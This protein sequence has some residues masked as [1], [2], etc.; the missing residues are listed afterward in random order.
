LF[1][2][3][4]DCVQLFV[5]VTAPLP[6]VQKLIDAL[7]SYAAEHEATLSRIQDWMSLE[8]GTEASC[9]KFVEEFP[10]T[11]LKADGTNVAHRPFFCFIL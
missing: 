2:V 7:H 6:C 8:N 5:L 11:A 9:E 10:E 1:D 4:E 3:V